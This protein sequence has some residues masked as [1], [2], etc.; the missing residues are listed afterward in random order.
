MKKIAC[1]LFII[2]FL[3][4][5]GAGY[6]LV[7]DIDVKIYSNPLE[8]N[9]EY[10]T[11]SFPRNADEVTLT[12]VIDCRNTGSEVAN[13]CSLRVVLPLP[14][15]LTLPYSS[16]IYESS[17]V[18]FLSRTGPIYMFYVTQLQPGEGFRIIIHVT[19]DLSSIPSPDSAGLPTCVT[20]QADAYFWNSDE[21][22]SFT[23]NTRFCKRDDGSGSDIDLWIA[24]DVNDIDCTDSSVSYQVTFG[25][26]GTQ[27]CEGVTILDYLP[28]NS[29]FETSTFPPDSSTSNYL[30]WTGIRL[31]PGEVQSFNL[32]LAL[33]NPDSGKNYRNF[34]TI[35]S[36]SFETDYS[37]N[38]SAVLATCRKDSCYD[39]TGE[40]F[41]NDQNGDLIAF[42][43][44]TIY[45]EVRISNAGIIT[46]YD[47]EAW[48][49]YT[50]S[51]LLAESYDFTVSLD[52]L[53]AS[54]QL[55]LFDTITLVEGCNPEYD[56]ITA[57]VDVYP[58]VEDC[59]STNN[60]SLVSL[61]YECN[62]ECPYP[63]KASTRILT[64]DNDGYNDKVAFYPS[65]AVKVEIYDEKGILVRMLEDAVSWDG[66]D[67]DGVL[68]SSG[69]YIWQM[70]CPFYET[71]KV[72]YTGTIAIKRK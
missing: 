71:E 14:N 70:Y 19:I 21:F 50:S 10:D 72:F 13:N 33:I 1:L 37:N 29:L 58:R 23:D 43:S 25:N 4:K 57:T 30:E 52:S 59:D 62:V 17:D 68:L 69:L 11:Y 36:D 6:Q 5:V 12:Y 24:K 61:A 35:K 38:Y 31:D 55:I 48:I 26:A 54:E 20:I 64:P 46:A 49:N 60:V 2:L 65:E 15:Y 7:Q 9:G 66:R 51:E 16:P 32:I 3:V 41:L 8:L 27:V 45:C 67:E 56:E 39:L 63:A 42:P 34:I 47:V 40:I 18:T 22:E 44:E 28:L 53:A